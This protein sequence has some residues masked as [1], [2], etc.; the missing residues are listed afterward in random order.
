M[1]FVSANT[2][3]LVKL[4]CNGPVSRV[5]LP[6]RNCYDAGGFGLLRNYADETSVLREELLFNI[7]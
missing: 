2:F 6:P 7:A 1:M 5:D 3:F 4:P